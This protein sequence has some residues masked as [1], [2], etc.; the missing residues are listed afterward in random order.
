MSPRV[1]IWVK[2]LLWVFS[3]PITGHADYRLLRPFHCRTFPH[4]LFPPYFKKKISIPPIVSEGPFPTPEEAGF[5][6]YL[7]WQLPKQFQ[8]IILSTLSSY[9]LFTDKGVQRTNTNILHFWIV[10]PTGPLKT[11]RQLSI[12]Y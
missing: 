8:G 11:L 4:F 12:Y 10:A 3:T 1:P 6:L 9:S 2:F 7:S 5:T